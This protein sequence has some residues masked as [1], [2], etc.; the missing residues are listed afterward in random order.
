MLIFYV[1][2][3]PHVPSEVWLP[4]VLLHKQRR[5]LSP[6][7]KELALS[8]SSVGDNFSVMSRYAFLRLVLMLGY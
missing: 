1:M 2:L 8:K 4:I 7:A 5:K 6:C 3:V